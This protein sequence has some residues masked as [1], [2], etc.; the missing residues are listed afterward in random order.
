[1]M[2]RCVVCFA[3]A[4]LLLGIGGCSGRD[5]ALERAQARYEQARQMTTVRQHAPVE[6]DLARQALTAAEAVG[7]DERR[8]KAYIVERR[9]AIAEARANE[10][11]YESQFEEL[12]QER[13][14]MLR[15][16]TSETAAA[17]QARAREAEEELARLRQEMDELESE[18]TERGLVLTFG[19]VLFETGAAELEPGAARSVERLAAFLE[20]N[21]DNRVVIEGHTDSTGDP[22]FNRQLSKRRADAVG[23]ALVTYGI[24]PNRISTHGYGD[25]LP[26]APNETAAGRQENRRVEVV[27]ETIDN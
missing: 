22:D 20:E 3:A 10:R 23:D 18:Q 1:M 21:P 13:Q 12:G 4:I 2:R 6:L 5:A 17:A 8:H 19:D 26:V 16:R 27:V 15:E 9:V 7:G 14:R 24:A 11:L 25:S